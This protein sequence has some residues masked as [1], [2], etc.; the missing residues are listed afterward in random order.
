MEEEQG[1]VRKKWETCEGELGEERI[2]GEC[3][4]RMH[5]KHL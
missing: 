1:L 4:I 5:Y 3:V 2:G